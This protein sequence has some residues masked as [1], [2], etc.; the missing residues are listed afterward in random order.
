MASS[1]NARSGA[2]APRETYTLHLVL[3]DG[4]HG[5]RVVVTMNGRK[6]YQGAKITTDAATGRADARE[7]TSK[8][9]V[10]RLVVSARP[11]NRDAAFDVDVAAR[12]HVAISLV[13]EG[14]VAFE[15]SALPFR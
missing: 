3:R 6:I 15:T 11:G 8:S 10:A 1:R 12:P 7:V 2:S 14:T 5:H 9:R 4:F 13:G